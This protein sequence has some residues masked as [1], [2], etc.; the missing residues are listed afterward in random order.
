MKRIKAAGV[1]GVCLFLGLAASA[2][3]AAVQVAGAPAYSMSLRQAWEYGGGL[4]WVLAAMSVFGLAMVFYFLLFL[5]E[6]QIAPRDLMRDLVARIKADDLTEARRLCEDRPCPL[7]SV[8]LAVLDTLRNAPKSDLAHLRDAAES[9]GG[10]QADSINGLI[11]LLLDLSVIAPMVGLLGTVMG[12]LQAFGSIA[13]DVASAR[14]IVL[15]AG[16]SQA[17]ITTIFGL[18]V[19]IPAMI[20]YAGFRR[21]ASR[22]IASLENAAAQ[23]AAS[24]MD[25]YS[26]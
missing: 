3:D 21:R 16:V 18:L 12:M 15:A 14:P 6:S 10:R 11:Q 9:E 17:I 19:A 5:R 22:Q 26:K 25:R 2:Q 13:S 20:C 23:I 24:L 7:S 8:T 4:M 1:S